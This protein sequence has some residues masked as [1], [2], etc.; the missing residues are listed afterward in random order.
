[1]DEITFSWGWGSSCLQSKPMT[2]GGDLRCHQ[3][4]ATEWILWN[5]FVTLTGLVKQMILGSESGVVWFFYENDVLGKYKNSRDESELQ[6]TVCSTMRKSDT[7]WLRFFAEI[8][9]LSQVSLLMHWYSWIQIMIRIT[10]VI[11][12]VS[13]VTFIKNFI[14]V[15]NFLC[16]KQS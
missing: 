14:E 1:M 4:Y 12:S 16:N 3:I 7:L 8:R 2:D 15:C 9:L 6:V 5:L 11:L 13:F 10:I